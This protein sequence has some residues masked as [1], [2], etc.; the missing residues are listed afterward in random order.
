M[1]AWQEIFDLNAR[2][3]EKEVGLEAVREV[4]S[5]TPVGR[6]ALGSWAAPQLPEHLADN[7]NRG[8]RT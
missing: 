1:W 8:F 2:G 4:T 5:Q 3:L 7:K 6:A